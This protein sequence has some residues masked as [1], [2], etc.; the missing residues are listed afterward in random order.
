[1][2]IS[3]E[4]AGGFAGM[5]VAHTVD[6]DSLSADDARELHQLVEAACFFDLPAVIQS[7]APGGDQF[8][9]KLTVEAG[10]RT[11]TVEAGDAAAPETLQPL[12]LRLTRLARS[13]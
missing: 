4:R 7:S 9:Y 3:F 8:Q 12:L 1:M 6:T 2:K 11:H 10:G 5:R 13:R